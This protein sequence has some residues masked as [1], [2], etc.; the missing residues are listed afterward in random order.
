V[1]K[2]GRSAENLQHRNLAKLKSNFKMPSA[3]NN[4]DYSLTE[5]QKA[6]FLEVSAVTAYMGMLDRISY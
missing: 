5:E 1:F 2:R 6:H 3:T 4:P